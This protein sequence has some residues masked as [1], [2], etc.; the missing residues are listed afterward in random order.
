MFQPYGRIVVLHIAIL[1]GAFAVLALGSN[2]GVLL[3][4]IVGKTALDLGF[5]VW[6]RQYNANGEPAAATA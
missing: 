3:I 4:L 2:I 5:H 6:E 1:L